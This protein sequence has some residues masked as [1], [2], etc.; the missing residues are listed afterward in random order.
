MSSSHYVFAS[1]AATTEKPAYG[2]R[3]LSDDDEIKLVYWEKP[4]SNID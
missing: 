1:I 2:A 3:Q 4:K